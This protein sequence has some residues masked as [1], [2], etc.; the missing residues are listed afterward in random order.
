MGCSQSNPNAVKGPDA[1]K[2]PATGI[3]GKAAPT[4]A[5]VTSTP[6]ANP[7]QTPAGTTPNPVKQ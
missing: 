4:T 3:D 7:I 6:G 5:G 2:V 1:T